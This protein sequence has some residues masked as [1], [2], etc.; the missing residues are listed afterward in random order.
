M[1][2][3]QAA[4]SFL[5]MWMSNT[6]TTAMMIP[7]VLAV[8]DELSACQRI[9]REDCNLDGVHRLE[10]DTEADRSTKQQKSEQQRDFSNEPVHEIRLY[11]ALLLS[12]CYSANIGGTGTLTG[13]GSNVVMSGQLSM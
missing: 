8:I 9:Q 13:T 12:I 1:L 11:K 4:T 3:L 10:M 7:I 6:A 2:G 5:S